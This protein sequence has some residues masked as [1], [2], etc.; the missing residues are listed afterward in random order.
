M[1]SADYI[2]QSFSHRGTTW[3]VDAL[4]SHIAGCPFACS[5][6]GRLAFFNVYEIL[7]GSAALRTMARRAA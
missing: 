7:N 5:A 2:G 1:K 4:A 6:R 3:N